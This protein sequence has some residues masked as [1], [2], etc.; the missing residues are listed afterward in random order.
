M[1]E[2]ISITKVYGQEPNTVTA[3]DRVT[4]KLNPNELTAVMGPSGSGKTTL[5]NIIGCLDSATAG[6]YHLDGENVAGLDLKAKARLRNEMFGFVFQAFNLLPDK[7]VLDNVMIPSR[8]S[9]RPRKEW[10]P[11]AM[12]VLEQM[13]IADLALRYPDQLSGGQQQ[14]VAIAR[15]LV[16]DPKVI[17]ADEPTGNLDSATGREI[18]DVLKTLADKQGKAVVVV[19]HD[20]MVASQAHRLL[21]MM[22]SRIIDDSMLDSGSVVFSHPNF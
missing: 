18:V 15:A 19:T 20:G 2:L 12:A 1:I 3:L 16:N 17:L 9:R 21:Q 7:T 5:L 8:Y 13:G 14:R 4:L 22:D 10:K 6:E 11:K